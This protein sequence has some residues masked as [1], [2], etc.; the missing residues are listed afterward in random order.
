VSTGK[1]GRALHREHARLFQ[2]QHKT[3]L[4]GE[5]FLMPSDKPRCLRRKKN[6][7]RHRQN[8]VGTSTGETA[9]SS[10]E[11]KMCDRLEKTD[12]S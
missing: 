12:E 5:L 3:A 8:F 10:T 6:F 9:E 2:T 4:K 11:R 1:A 7:F